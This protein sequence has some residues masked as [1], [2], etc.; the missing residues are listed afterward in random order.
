[1]THLTSVPLRR[2]NPRGHGEQLRD[3]ILDAADTLL[4]TTGDPSQ[5]SLRGVA[6][7]VGIAATSVYL[8][9]PDVS[10]LKIAVVMRAFSRLDAAR[11]GAIQ[12][13]ADPV[14]ALLMRLQSYT[15]FALE[16]PGRYRLMFGPE[17]PAILAYEAEQSPGRR[18][19]QSLVQSIRRCQEAGVAPPEDDPQQVAVLVWTALHGMVLLRLDLPHF[20]WPS[21]EGMVNEMVLRLVRS[22]S[23]QQGL[24]V[25]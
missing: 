23:P 5:L 13:I 8:H 24:Q 20:P 1:M 14:A 6:K 21:L 25:P 15:Q 10:E 17:L 12:G 11:D 3:E 4:S 19:F 2:R 18:S 7:H 16:N 22:D 9:F